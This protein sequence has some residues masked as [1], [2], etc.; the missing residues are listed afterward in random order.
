MLEDNTQMSLLIVD[1]LEDNR[2]LLRLDLEDEL[3]GA[4]IDEAS[5]GKEALKLI[6][7]NDY[8]VVICDFMMPE[9]D[10]FELFEE[11]KRRCE[12]D[13]IPPFIF[14]SANKQKEVAE[15]GLRLGAMDFMTKPYDLLELIF[16]IKNLARIKLLN[17]SLKKSKERMAEVNKKLEQ[18]NREKDDVL[19]IVSHDMKDPLNSIQGL[20]EMIKDEEYDQHD[21]P[22]YGRIIYRSS[23]KLLNLV[24]TLLEMSKIESGNLNI[25][26][27]ETNVG[28]LLEEVVKSFEIKADQKNI[29]LHFRNE[30]KDLTYPLDCTRFDQIAH[31]LISNAIKFTPSGG[32][33]EVMLDELPNNNSAE[34]TH[35][36][37]LKVKDT[38]IGIPEDMLPTLF[39]KFSTNQ[40][41][42][43][44]K[45]QGNGLGLYIVKQLTELLG[46]TVNVK[47]AEGKG[48]SFTLEFR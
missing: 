39:D 40:R 36:F 22:E 1:D 14:L 23:E 34:G 45:E 2:M 7:D 46:G 32:T 26:K 29:A 6:C 35:G 30:D 9:M 17:D 18:A 47:S 16:K 20:S 41:H 31:N 27:K 28:E 8:S 13:E 15:E 24:N 43:T 38:G 11:V 10:G 48:T 4:G 44:E 19:R 3:S 5:G 25:A 12:P 33:V 37:K 42:G 21:V